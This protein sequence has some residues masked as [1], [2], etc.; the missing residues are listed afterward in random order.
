MKLLDSKMKR[1]NK[2]INKI[3]YLDWDRNFFGFSIGR[4]YAKGITEGHFRKGLESAKVGNI[5]FVELFCDASDDESIDSSERLGFH[6]AD[7]RI[8]LKKTLE[9]DIIENRT[10]KDLIFKKAEGA[11]IDRL[12]TMS[13]GIFKDSRYY[14]YQNFDSNNIDL[15]FQI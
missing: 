1:K 11:D 2:E 12:K 5:E 15:M 4:I 7:L 9:R 8:T 6:L 14:R 13:K 3:I 10:P